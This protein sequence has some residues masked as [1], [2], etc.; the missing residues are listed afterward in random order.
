VATMCNLENRPNTSVLARRC[1]SLRLALVALTVLNGDH[2]LLVPEAYALDTDEGEW[3]PS[4][5]A[6]D[7][8]RMPA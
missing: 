7:E 2:S 8:P 5:C 4:E 6:C 1:K 3:R